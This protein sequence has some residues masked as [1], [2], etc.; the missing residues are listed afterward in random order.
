[1]CDGNVIAK[2][3]KHQMAFCEIF[4][5]STPFKFATEET[6]PIITNRQANLLNEISSQS[7]WSTA[8]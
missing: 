1:M 6:W 8:K 4:R 3:M 7:D 2:D 5:V